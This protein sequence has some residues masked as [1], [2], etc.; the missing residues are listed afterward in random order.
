MASRFEIY[1]NHGVRTCAPRSTQQELVT[2]QGLAL[3]PAD[4]SRL[5]AQGMPVNTQNAQMFYD[6]DP[7]PSPYV[8]SERR[9]GV[10][11]SDLWEE[12]QNIVKKARAAHAEMKKQKSS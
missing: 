9:R 5:T 4:V 8:T 3:T 6:G 10:D 1:K 11:V 12:R 7:N 2:R